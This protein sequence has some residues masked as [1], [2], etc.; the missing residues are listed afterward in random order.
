MFDNL[1]VLT[2]TTIMDIGISC[3]APGS[4]PQEM[5]LDFPYSNARITAMNNALENKTSIIIYRNGTPEAITVEELE[6]LLEQLKEAKSKA[7]G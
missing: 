6:E 3:W 4:L 1:P 7:N 2:V 5:N